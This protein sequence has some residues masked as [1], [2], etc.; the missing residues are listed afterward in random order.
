[1]RFFFICSHQIQNLVPLFVELDKKKVI[2]FKVIFWEKLD[3]YHFDYEFN[4]KINFKFNKFEN[5]KYYCLSKNKNNS[6]EI[7]SFLNKILITFK[8]LTFLF[9]ERRNF[10]SVLIYGYYFPNIISSIFLKFLGKKIILRSVS[11]NLGIRNFIK[12]FSRN[13]Y[14]RFSNIFIDRFWS[15]CKLNTEFF[16]SFG[17]KES[18]ISLIESSQIYKSFVFANEEE[19]VAIKDRIISQNKILL[20]KKII[21]FVG[22]LIEKKRPLF[23]LEAFIESKINDDWV[24]LIA[25]DGYYRKEIL[26]FINN[27]KTKNISFLG[28]Q[29]LQEILTLYSLS[30]IVV[31][32]SDYGE[33]HGNVLM[34]A[35]QFKCALIASN[36]VGIYP[37]LIDNNIG[38]VFDGSNKLDLI[39]K[40]ENLTNDKI[41]LEELKMNSFEYSEKIKPTY[42]ANKML[43]DLIKK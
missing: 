11:Y 26:D 36:R 19:F 31:L 7:F 28:F 42:V 8:L 21:L 22:K 27:N 37:E 33:T 40:L 24:L 9:K 4:N 43:E 10:D 38:L 13:I 15:I 12:K 32:P 16:K 29:N 18:K 14:Y 25:G 41:L 2:D 35:T 23:L 1:M 39:K 20:N 5:Y 3:D 6:K 17:V 34:E 30:E